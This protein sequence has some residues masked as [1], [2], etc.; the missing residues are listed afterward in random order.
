MSKK[1]H[2]FIWSLIK[3]IIISIS[4]IESPVSTCWCPWD[5]WWSS[6]G[7][8]VVIKTRKTLKYGSRGA[9][10]ENSIIDPRN[11]LHN[12]PVSWEL[13]QTDI[14]KGTW[15]YYVH[16]CIILNINRHI[17]LFAFE[18][19]IFAVRKAL[20]TSDCILLNVAYYYVLCNCYFFTFVIKINCFI[21]SCSIVFWR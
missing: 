8:D 17:Q 5:V 12:L 4:G 1:V 9:S 18:K 14:F 7:S 19:H 11:D 16:F 10:T 3:N 13:W 21:Y 20:I 2:L 15:F 6:S